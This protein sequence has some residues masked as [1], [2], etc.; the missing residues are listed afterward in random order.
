MSPL[1]VALLHMSVIF[2]FYEK[3]TPDDFSAESIG[4]PRSSP[5][6]KTF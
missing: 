5:P 6:W 4:P 1:V 3:D 2:S